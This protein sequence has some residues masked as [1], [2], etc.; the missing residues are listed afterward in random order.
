MDFNIVGN[1]LG[2][3]KL[4]IKIKRKSLTNA[5]VVFAMIKF[6]RASARLVLNQEAW[7]AHPVCARRF[8]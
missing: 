6:P 2:L 8:S 7:C 4:Y 3:L 5:L 1:Q